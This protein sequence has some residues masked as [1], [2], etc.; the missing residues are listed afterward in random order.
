MSETLV[1][2]NFPPLR[3]AN[4]LR[5]KHAYLGCLR[6]TRAPGCKALHLVVIVL[7]VVSL[8]PSWGVHGRDGWAGVE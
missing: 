2:Y 6:V 4:I 7:M 3:L 5:A 8:S 1:R